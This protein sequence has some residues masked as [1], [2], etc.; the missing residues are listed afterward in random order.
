MPADRED[1][2]E[3]RRI[4]GRLVTFGEGTED[5]RRRALRSEFGDGSGPPGCSMPSISA[6]LLTTDRD[7]ASR[8]PTVEVAH[9][10]LLR[11]W[12]RLRDWLVEDREL[13]RSVGAIGV[14]ATVWDRGGRQTSDLYRGGRL[15]SALRV[16]ETS[17]DWLRPID[18][19]FLDASQLQAEA[20]RSREQRRVRRLRR[21]VAGTAAALVIALVAGGVA[22]TQQRRA[23]RAARAAE[24]RA[25]EAAA[26]TADAELAELIARSA[27]AAGDRPDQALLLALEA[28]QRAPGSATTGAL[29]DAIASGGFGRQVDAIDRLGAR[30]CSGF[31]PQRLLA[32]DGRWEFATV[33]PDELRVGPEALRK[34][35]VS[36]EVTSGGTSPAPCASWWEDVETARRWAA[37]TTA[38]QH[39]IGTG[40]GEWA[41]V[42]R[43]L[44]GDAL[45]TVVVDDRLLWGQARFDTGA[46]VVGEVVVVDAATLEEVAP[47]IPELG[48]DLD[49]RIP[50]GA[51]SRS[52]GLFAVGATVPAG[53]ENLD[54]A[55]ARGLLVVL[56]AAT[57]AEV[58][59]VARPGGVTAVAFDPDGQ[60][61][62]AGAD[63][64]TIASI[65]VASGEVIDVVT[66][67]EPSEVIRL[68]ASDDDVIVAVSRRSIEAFDR[69]TGRSAA[70]IDIPSASDAR[71]RPDGSVVVVP[72]G[73]PA[74][75]RVVD[76]NGGPLVEQGWDVDRDALVGFG[77][78]R[79]AVVSPSGGAEVVELT[80][81]VRTDIELTTRDGE[82]FDPVAMTPEADG[83]LAWNDGRLI[84]RW[85]GGEL[86]E[87]L[88]LWSGLNQVS[89]TRSDWAYL[90]A[91]DPGDAP[92]VGGAFASSGAVAVFEGPEVKAWYL[93]DPEPGNLATLL[94]GESP[95]F[96]TSAVAPGP[97]GGVHV[98]LKD[99]TVRTYDR[100]GTR[101]SEFDAGLVDASVAVTD[102]STGLVALAGENG[103][104]V[105][106]PA[107]ESIQSVTDVGAVVSLG[108]AREGTLLVVVE[109]DGTV[110]LWD[111]Q[112]AEAVGT[113]WN[114][115]GTAP[116]S[117][118]WFDESTDTIWVATSG[119]ILQFS[120]DPDRWVERV[121]ELVSRELT[122]GEWERLVPGDEPQRPA[123]G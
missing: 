74:T 68:G 66:M 65:D 48:W 92:P 44:S 52:A 101:A 55:D 41:P 51:A 72:D 87:Q 70:P 108:F 47:A 93:F 24:A 94:V 113:L 28:R 14:A 80:S 8:E 50:P 21:L 22:F 85:R 4:F 67:S 111:T 46:S 39:W 5:T 84:A 121:C 123:C 58:F 3:A 33:G 29:L 88:E 75:L 53:Q 60:F 98:V 1:E 95:I 25:E 10:A 100:A 42:S 89:L 82:V 37:S 90:A 61:L 79:A 9:E 17:P 20:E 120:L 91:T 7:P 114:G 16:A 56:E 97:E 59:R 96:S 103:A 32:P 11:D 99:G 54:V 2:A 12:P 13:R 19:E 118:P 110:R 64:G 112:H 27:A 105:V 31:L 57:G 43:L 69:S 23:D 34:D 86:V 73:E 102:A 38:S 106:D 115:D 81:G 78:G 35:L 49:G 30:S 18:H 36:G 40:A 63:D 122:P 77:G 6:R 62:L 71:V 76:P 109:L 83:F 116:A 26:A 107:T 15:D 45:V 117:P 104:V 119:K